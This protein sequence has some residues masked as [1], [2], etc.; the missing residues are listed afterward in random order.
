M[1]VSPTENG[2][3]QKIVFDGNKFKQNVSVDRQRSFCGRERRFQFAVP[4]DIIWESLPI[5]ISG[6]I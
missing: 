4:W 5:Y 3:C 6:Q 1:T 2:V